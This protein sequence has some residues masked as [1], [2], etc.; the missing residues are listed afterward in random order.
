MRVYRVMVEE[1]TYYHGCRD[2]ESVTYAGPTYST[3]EEAERARDYYNKTHKS[4]DNYGCIAWVVQIQILDK[5][6]KEEFN[7]YVK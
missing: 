6:D 5:F 2:D 3:I 4:T 7:K 1:S